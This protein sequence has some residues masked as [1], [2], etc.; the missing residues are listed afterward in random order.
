MN[1]EAPVEFMYRPPGYTEH[2]TLSLALD[3]LFN[4]IT[5]LKE[6]VYDI[7]KELQDL[8]WEHESLYSDFHDYKRNY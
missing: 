5:L 6:D 7:K 8:R 2:I 3:T 4:E 1:E